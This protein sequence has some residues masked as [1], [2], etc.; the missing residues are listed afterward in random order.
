MKTRRYSSLTLFLC[1][2]LGLAACH[3]PARQS[4]L[5]PDLDR[6]AQ[7]TIASEQET[8]KAPAAPWEI[9]SPSFSRDN[10][11]NQQLLNHPRGFFI[12]RFRRGVELESRG[13]LLQALNSYTAAEDSLQEVP[14]YDF[15]AR[16]MGLL[17]KLGRSQD[18]LRA[19]S[20][21][22]SDSGRDHSSLAP[23]L[24]YLAAQ[25]YRHQNNPEQVIAWVKL[26]SANQASLDGFVN[27]AEVERG[28]KNLFSETLQE[29]NG[30]TL[31]NLSREWPRGT[32]FSLLIEK[33]QA[34]RRLGLASASPS[35]EFRKFFTP[36]F[37]SETGSQLALVSQQPEARYG[38]SLDR[39]KLG[40]LLPLS[41]R[42]APHAERVKKG[43]EMALAQSDLVGKVDLIFRDTGGEPTR[44]VEH[45]EN[46]V[47]QSK[48][49]LVFGPLLVKTTEMV[50]NQAEVLGVPIIAFTK[51]PGIPDLSPKV[52]RLGATTG[53]QVR[54]LVRYASRKLGL[55]TFAILY[56]ERSSGN[57]FARDF[58]EFVA[59]DGGE[60]LFEASY[61]P[62]DEEEMAAAARA[63]IA[64]GVVS[65]KTAGTTYRNF[66][67]TPQALF[68]ADSLE[69]ASPILEE[70]QTL[71]IEQTEQRPAKMVLLGQ[72]E[73]TDTLALRG[74]G[75]LLE[76]ATFVSPFNALS[77][78]PKVEK[79]TFGF[80]ERY[81]LQPELL[82]AQSFDATSLVLDK[83]AR[84]IMQG[85]NPREAL[86]AVGSYQGVT[87]RLEIEPNGEITREMSVIRLQSG[88]PQ[89]VRY[90]GVD[91]NQRSS[92]V[93]ER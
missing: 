51:K 40:V 47:S 44:A 35:R 92:L 88:S 42:F 83:A 49:S 70:I 78:D 65:S 46:L 5:G 38:E 18:A 17:L 89:E 27:H 87:G 26:A 29:V 61:Y 34:D 28:V 76:G 19:L 52:F 66:A 4:G 22:S 85:L 48:V 14:P 8:F 15:V 20:K 36:S 16:K 55:R 23:I 6:Q 74:Y 62:G 64:G 57:D 45:Y 30:R 11:S 13:E 10:F 75:N 21:Y 71:R 24:C 79:F 50:A 69:A 63:L 12:S 72:A 32:D 80:K 1:V 73:W 77:Q 67:K 9:W 53:D 84:R 7:V 25:G 58:R 37:Y 93:I 86:M 60:L 33:Q 2:L 90:G 41:G 31:G 56:P 43:I 82:S 68:I 91:I 54:E 59:V 3:S 39:L 81:K